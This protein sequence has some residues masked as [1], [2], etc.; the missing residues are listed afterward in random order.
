MLDLVE[1]WAI[2]RERLQRMSVMNQCGLCVPL[3]MERG[4]IHDKDRCGRQFEQQVLPH[5]AS[6]EIDINIGIEQPDG[7]QLLPNQRTT[8]ALPTSNRVA[9]PVSVS[10]SFFRTDKTLH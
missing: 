1:V 5:P 2:G 7:Q 10:P 4:T 9:A 6:I 8:L 3:L